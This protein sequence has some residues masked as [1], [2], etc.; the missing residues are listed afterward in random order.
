MYL[1]DM[2]TISLNIVGNPGISVPTGL[3]VDTGLPVGIQLQGPA[4]GDAD[5]LR[6]ARAVERAFAGESGEPALSVAPD[7]AGK[8]GELA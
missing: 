8:G 4:F 6:Y 3:G 1:S 7:F 5:L 2:Y